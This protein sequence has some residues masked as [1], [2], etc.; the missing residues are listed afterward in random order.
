MIEIKGKYNTAEVFTDEIE[1]ETHK[2]ILEM[3]NLKELENSTIKIMPDCHA[4]KGCTIG[5]TIMMPDDT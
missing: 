2:Q 5:T 1:K 3:C 4:G